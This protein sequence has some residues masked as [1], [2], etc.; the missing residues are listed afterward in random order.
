MTSAKPNASTTPLSVTIYRFVHQ[1]VDSISM[2]TI[3]LSIAI[4]FVFY[5]FCQ[6]KRT[7]SLFADSIGIQ[8]TPL[9]FLNKHF[10]LPPNDTAGRLIWYS[11]IL[12]DFREPILYSDT[13]ETIVYRLFTIG[14]VIRIEKD[15]TSCKIIVKLHQGAKTIN[16][17]T[18]DW[19]RLQKRIKRSNYWQMKPRDR[20]GHDGYNFILEARVGGCYK[21][22]DRWCPKKSRYRRLCKYI[23]ELSGTGDE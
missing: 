18:Q 21:V 7:I 2:K 8:D 22:V 20:Q 6:E 17:S 10:D 16:V 13:S 19:N 12:K 23:I 1:E 9:Y 15:S 3:L 4:T 5:A 14:R 11:W